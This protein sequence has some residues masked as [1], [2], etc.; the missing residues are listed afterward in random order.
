MK[1]SLDPTSRQAERDGQKLELRPLEFDLL[2]Y[3]ATREGRVVKADDLC[4]ALWPGE[5]AP[6]A[7]LT[8]HL[9]NLRLALQR[10]GPPLVHSVPGGYLLAPAP[11]PSARRVRHKAK[12]GKTR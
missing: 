11:P 1:L 4:A 5:A 10:T 8:V 3:L 9:H 7:R 12:P 2:L 6:R